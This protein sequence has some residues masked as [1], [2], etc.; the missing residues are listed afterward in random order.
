FANYNI[1]GADKRIAAI[2]GLTDGAV[3]SG[4]LAFYAWNAGTFGERMRITATG[5]VGIG[6]T[7]PG[8]LLD[9]NKTVDGGYHLAFAV[10]ASPKYGMFA[11]SSGYLQF[12]SLTAGKNVLT[13]S[14]AGN[15]GIGSTNP[16]ALLDTSRPHDTGWNLRL[17]CTGIG[18]A[19]QNVGIDFY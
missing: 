7:N 9:L 10:T 6:S 17:S 19:N 13:L 8:A 5:N 1:A 11:H 12:D 14:A 4:A 3:N 18:A 16:Q 15:V 2:A